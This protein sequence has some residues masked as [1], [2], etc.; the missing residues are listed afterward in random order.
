MATAFLDR[1][2]AVPV[3]GISR[4]PGRTLAAALVARGDTRRIQ[5]TRQFDANRYA[6]QH[7]ERVRFTR[8]VL[9]A[10]RVDRAVRQRR[11]FA[12]RYDRIPC[13]ILPARADGRT[14][15]LY[16]THF[17]GPACDP[18]ASANARRYA[19]R[20]GGAHLTRRFTVLVGPAFAPGSEP[21]QFTAQIQIAGIAGISVGADAPRTVAFRHANRVG[22]AL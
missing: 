19:V 16:Q 12:F 2:T 22:P 6:F 20:Y 11:F 4:V 9:L 8:F 15:F 17:V 10:V 5:R 18:G 21:F 3:V 13:E 14:V 1:T 7:A